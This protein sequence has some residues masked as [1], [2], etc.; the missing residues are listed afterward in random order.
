MPQF[1]LACLVLVLAQSVYVLF[2]FGSGLIAVG[3]MALF[4]PVVTDIVVMLL[5]LGLPVELFVV[6]RSRKHINWRGV[7]PLAAGMIAGVF[8]GTWIL[9]SG[10]PR[11][12]LTV[13]GVFLLVTGAAFLVIDPNRRVRWPGWSGPPVG[14]LGG[15]LAGLFG[16]GGPPLIFYYRLSGVEKAVFRGNLMTIFLIAALVRFPSYLQAGFL[17]PE[18]ILGAA[19]LL[20]AAGLGVFI[21]NRAHI[22][23]SELRFKQL[24]SGGLVVIGLLLLV[25]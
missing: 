22:E 18:R 23:L 14:L 13:L 25:R 20:P 2:G 11:F 12:V 15:T 7:L 17:T 21:G 3:L 4:M 24:V 1:I 10:E 6:A 8:L 5:L 9:K 19:A 16:T